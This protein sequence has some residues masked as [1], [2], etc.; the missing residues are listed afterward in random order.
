MAHQFNGTQERSENCTFSASNQ[1]HG[2]IKI[3]IGDFTA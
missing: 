2:S 3:E 1:V